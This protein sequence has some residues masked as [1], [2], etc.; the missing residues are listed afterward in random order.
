MVK[1]VL[2]TL[3]IMMSCGCSGIRFSNPANADIE[4]EITVY[5]PKT[6]EVTKTKTAISLDN[7]EMSKEGMTAG[8][9]DGEPYVGTSGSDNPSVEDSKYAQLWWAGIGLIALGLGMC[10]CIIS[11]A[12][13]LGTMPWSLPG[14]CIGLGIVAIKFKAITTALSIGLMIAVIAGVVALMVVPGLASN[15]R[16]WLKTNITTPSS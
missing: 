6:G 16:R 13:I 5:N 15:M 4:Q 9:R 3:M 2:F 8:I 12:P 10:Y 7:D 14:A 1:L 11:R